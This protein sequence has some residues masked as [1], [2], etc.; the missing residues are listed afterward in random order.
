[1]DPTNPLRLEL[2][3]STVQSLIQEQLYPQAATLIQQT[4]SSLQ[5]LPPSEQKDIRYLIEELNQLENV[6]ETAGKEVIPK[7]PKEAA[8]L[9]DSMIAELDCLSE[10][11]YKE[12]TLFMQR[13]RDY[14][15]ASTS[16]CESEQ[17]RRRSVSDTMALKETCEDSSSSEDGTGSWN[18]PESAVDDYVLS[19]CFDQPFDIGSSAVPDTYEMY[20]FISEQFKSLAPQQEMISTGLVQGRGEERKMPLSLIP[21]V[22]AVEK[23]IESLDVLEQFGQVPISREISECLFDHAPISRETNGR[24]V[25]QTSK[26]KGMNEGLFGQTSSIGG[27]DLR[28]DGG[29][30]GG[31][32][33]KGGRGSRGG[34]GLLFGQALS[35]KER[36]LTTSQNLF[37]PTPSSEE[38]SGNIFAPSSGMSGGLFGQAPS[39]GMSGGLFGQAPS[40]EGM[41]GNLFGQAP[42]TGGMSEGL[43]GQAPNTGGMCR[44]LFGPTPSSGGMGGGLFGQAPSSGGMSGNLFGQA[45][46]TGRVSGNLFDQVPSS[47]GMSGNPF[48][49][50][51]SSGGLFG[52]APSSG[53]MS[54][55]LFGQAPS[56]GGV[57]GG[58]FGQAP[59]S[60][61]TESSGLDESLFLNNK[62]RIKDTVALTSS[63]TVESTNFSD[64]TFCGGME[65]GDSF[66]ASSASTKKTGASSFAPA[67]TEGKEESTGLDYPTPTGGMISQAQDLFP[68]HVTKKSLFSNLERENERQSQ[69]QPLNIRENLINSNLILT[70][71]RSLIPPSRQ[72]SYGKPD[73]H[74]VFSK[75]ALSPLPKSQSRDDIESKDPIAITLEQIRVANY[76]I[77]RSKS[78]KKD[79]MDSRLTDTRKDEQERLAPALPDMES[80]CEDL[81]SRQSEDGSWSFSDLVT[82]QQ[83]LLKSPQHIQ[84]EM[85]ESG[86]KSLGVSLYSSLLRFIPTLLLLFF[87]HSAYSHSFEMAPSFISWSVIPPRWRSAGGEKGL[88][89]LRTFN[90]HNP[91]LSSR[92]DL[93]P[94]WME[95]ARQRIDL[96]GIL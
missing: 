58:L 49:Q 74:A 38:M 43:F 60:G 81:F 90:K 28:I 3:V 95:Y 25:S 14:I 26:G 47:K 79:K 48:V 55:N 6:I 56:S 5:P 78:L 69:K 27:M 36:S 37:G 4:N 51:P 24:P 84:R 19:E 87:L 68:K 96:T 31:R 15:T 40:S 71:D 63:G 46:N 2:A 57:S 53:G 77:T 42:S 10:D 61:G 73:S 41:S 82:I 93:A 29:G 20:S 34:M 72:T 66:F 17:R 67:P 52:Q 86:A 92:L 7:D 83:F 8:E 23:G 89:F 76:R 70:A 65:S 13:L 44:G 9:F 85:E 21:N 33:G 35:S 12:K 91:S 30:R 80:I 59:S 75:I 50:A 32:G 94:S 18:A 11:S 39:S 88:S 62:S 22:S 1:M 16:E 45:P 64:F 54:G